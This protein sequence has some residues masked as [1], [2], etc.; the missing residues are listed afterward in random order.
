[1]SEIGKKKNSRNRWQCGVTLGIILISLGL[2]TVHEFNRRSGMD[3]PLVYLVPEQYIGPVFVF[4]DQKDGVETIPDPLGSAVVVPRNGIIKLK[5]SVDELIP[6]RGGDNRNGYW[7]SVSKDKT[8]RIMI[9]NN[10]SERLDNGETEDAYLDE[11]GKVHSYRHRITKN[12]DVF[13]YFNA[14]KKRE[15]M[16]FGHEGCKHQRFAS[17]D[18]PHSA[19]PDCGKFLVISPNEFLEMP[20]WL[21]DETGGEYSSIQELETAAN[22]RAVK[23]EQLYK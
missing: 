23:I 21:W 6:D 5:R 9:L 20:R 17:A 15:R 3:K 8:R 13:F 19:L 2:L 14:Q 16:I 4:F 12:S 22:K 18:A 1:V 10:M 7:V 11:V